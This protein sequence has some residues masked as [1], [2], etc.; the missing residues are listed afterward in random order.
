LRAA[1]AKEK[2]LAQRVPGY[3]AWLASAS[4]GSVLMPSPTIKTQFDPILSSLNR[5]NYERE[6]M[7]LAAMNGSVLRALK[8]TSGDLEEL[9]YILIVFFVTEGLGSFF[10]FPIK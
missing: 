8:L 4:S 1:L 3:E 6:L 10:P 2:E 9:F 7:N 5:L